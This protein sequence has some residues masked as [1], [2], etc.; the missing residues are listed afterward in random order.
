MTERGPKGQQDQD[1][2]KLKGGALD[3]EIFVSAA[4]ATGKP[5][6]ATKEQASCAECRGTG[7]FGNRQC[8][9]C[10]GTGYSQEV[11]GDRPRSRADRKARGKA[12][13]G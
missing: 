13:S 8:H 6:K 2:K 11:G 1:A 9:A 5:P 10:N 3:F 12:K 4:M 7:R